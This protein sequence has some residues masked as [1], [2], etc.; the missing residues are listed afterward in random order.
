VLLANLRRRLLVGRNRPVRL[1][2]QHRASHLEDRSLLC[3]HH[4]A[5]FHLCFCDLKRACHWIPGGYK[6]EVARTKYVIGLLNA[7]EKRVEQD[8]VRAQD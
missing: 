6:V 7:Q 1:I 3:R 2:Y 5:K 8:E 4:L